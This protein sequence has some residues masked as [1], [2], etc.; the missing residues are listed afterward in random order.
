MKVPAVVFGTMVQ[1]PQPIGARGNRLELPQIS[2]EMP[3][4][5]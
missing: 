1:Q 2:S 4:D 5:G 3:H